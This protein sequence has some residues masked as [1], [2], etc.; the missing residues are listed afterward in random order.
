MPAFG[1]VQEL[2]LEHMR[3]GLRTPE[4]FSAVETFEKITAIEA[5]IMQDCYMLAME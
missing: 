4:V 3:N 2:W 1:I 5:A